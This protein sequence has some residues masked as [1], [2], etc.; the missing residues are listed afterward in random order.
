MPQLS[1][2]RMDLGS[3]PP[4]SISSES[5][6]ALTEASGGGGDG[7]GDGGEGGNQGDEGERSIEAMYLRALG[8]LVT[9]RFSPRGIPR[10]PAPSAGTFSHGALGMAAAR[11]ARSLHTLR[12]VVV[13][14]GALGAGAV[15]AS[16]GLAGFL[17]LKPADLEAGKQDVNEAAYK[18][19]FEEWMQKHER[20]YRNE[21][22]KAMR[23]EI[24]KE[25]ARSADELNASRGRRDFA[26]TEFAD[27]THEELKVLNGT[28]L[29]HPFTEEEYIAL[30]NT[31]EADR[32]K[33]LTERAAA[34]ARR[35]ANR[36]YYRQRKE[37]KK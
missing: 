18:A 5:R 10:R 21:E 28:R 16:V 8:S 32:A 1:Q 33:G 7:D 26:P 19:R 9:R 12:D 34:Q 35:D 20:I 25:T 14:G 17:Y 2:P 4:L 22:E 11:P 29:D 23:Y 37:E 13:G 6:Q 31:V 36:L 3:L 15:A 24:F 27:W 30:L